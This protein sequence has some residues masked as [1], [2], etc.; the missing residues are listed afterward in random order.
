M[1]E[2]GS[3]AISSFL[4]ERMLFTSKIGK[5][6]M[7]FPSYEKSEINEKV[8]FE[9]F[10]LISKFS[11]RLVFVRSFSASVLFL[12]KSSYSSVAI[13]SLLIINYFLSSGSYFIH[14]NSVSSTDLFCSMTARRAMAGFVDMLRFGSKVPLTFWL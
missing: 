6:K 4:F 5:P 10:L 9:L 12:T 1:V 2:I 13:F 14:K 7:H 3:F 11:R 8:L